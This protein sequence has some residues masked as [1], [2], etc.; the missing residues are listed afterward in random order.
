MHGNQVSEPD[1]VLTS[2]TLLGHA[3]VLEYGYKWA[4]EWC[5]SHRWFLTKSIN[6]STV[7]ML[8]G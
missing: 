7:S 6:D 1:F 2:S 8:S 3:L 4:G 5:V